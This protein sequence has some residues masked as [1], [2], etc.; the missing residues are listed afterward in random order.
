[1]NEILQK[2]FLLFLS[3]L[4]LVSFFSIEGF[5]V[6]SQPTTCEKKIVLTFDDGPHPKQ[7]MQILDF[8]DRYGI[9]ATFFMIGVNV[10]SYP[11]VA[12]EVVARGH[13]VGNHTKTH[14]HAIR[15][16]DA[17]LQ[18]EIEQCEREV[19]AQTGKQCR[20]FRP[21]EGALTDS[22]RSTIS[23]PDRGHP[24]A[25]RGLPCLGG[26]PRGKRVRQ[27]LR[28]ARALRTPCGV[29]YVA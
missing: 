1:M 6:S 8:L 20:L 15:I 29:L 10:E 16:D 21:P 26:L 9:K 13:E 23:L 17:L 14:S 5:A 12:H 28:R 27:A 25:A 18:T 3:I 2:T 22:M 24:K 19:L 7:T 11:Q 4:I